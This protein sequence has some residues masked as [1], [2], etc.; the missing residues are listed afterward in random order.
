MIRPRRSYLAVALVVTACD[1]AGQ[2]YVRGVVTQG[3][4][5][6]AAVR[7]TATSR[8][9]PGS[10]TIDSVATVSS[11]DGSYQFHFIHF[12][13]LGT[14]QVSLRFVPSDSS[15]RDTTVQTQVLLDAHSPGL[16]EVDVALGKGP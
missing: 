13:M 7:I 5:P 6:A 1:P 4:V 10:A 2:G 15:Y 8:V 14:L 9:P 11:S 12:L 3:G 16:S